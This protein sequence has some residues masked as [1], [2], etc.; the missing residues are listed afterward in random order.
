MLLIEVWTFELLTFM[1]G[2]LGPVELATQVLLARKKMKSKGKKRKKM[3][4]P[5][6]LASQVLLGRKKI[7]TFLPPSFRRTSTLNLKP[8]TL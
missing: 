4:G 1:A 5:V 8:Q 2:M 6:E 3:L 7:A